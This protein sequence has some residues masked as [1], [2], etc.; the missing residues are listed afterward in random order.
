MKIVEQGG[1][2]R[3]ALWEDGENCWRCGELQRGSCA[4]FGGPG[5]C[6]CERGDGIEDNLPLTATLLP[7]L[8]DQL[9][10][11]L[12]TLEKSTETPTTRDAPP[13]TSLTSTFAPPQLAPMA[14]P[15]MDTEAVRLQLNLSNLKRHDPHITAIVSSTSYASVYENR[16]EGWVRRL[17]LYCRR[18]L[19]N[20]GRSL[21]DLNRTLLTQLRF[22]LQVKTGVEGPMFLFSRYACRSTC[23]R[24]RRGTS[25]VALYAERLTETLTKLLT[26]RTTSP[27]YGF[28]VLNR[29]GLEYVQEFLTE[30][31][32]VKVEGEFILYEGGQDV[33]A[34]FLSFLP[35]SPP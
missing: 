5:Y 14:L 1:R 6:R 31:S 25:S 33:G 19:G 20:S 15:K 26:H 18:I 13:S 12:R 2:S 10:Y 16:G 34:F 28:F 23:I 24:E 27:S 32:E 11:T 21:F 7:L 4:A 30:E 3:I 9:K 17:P 29:Q 22:D 8:V 35:P